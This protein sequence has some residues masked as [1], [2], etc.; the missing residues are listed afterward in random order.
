[1]FIFIIDYWCLLNRCPP[2]GDENAV[3]VTKEKKKNNRH[4]KFHMSQFFSFFF[5]VVVVVVVV[6]V[7]CM[8]SSHP[9]KLLFL[10]I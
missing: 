3:P 2:S 1:M 7:G 4:M 9:N 10:H 8:N 6:V 5:V